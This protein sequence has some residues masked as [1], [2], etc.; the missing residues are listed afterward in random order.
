M[1]IKKSINNIAGEGVQEKE[2]SYTVG[3]N[4]SGCSHYGEQYGGSLKNQ[5]YSYHVIL[6]S[7]S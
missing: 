1:I 2:S 5:K 4:V 7:H 6:Q 3:G